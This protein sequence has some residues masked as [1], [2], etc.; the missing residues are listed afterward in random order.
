M[1]SKGRA[2]ARWFEEVLH[3]TIG[4]QDVT[5]EKERNA[6]KIK[7]ERREKASSNSAAQVAELGENTALLLMF[8]AAMNEVTHLYSLSIQY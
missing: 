7:M 4:K 8:S 6:K 1:P 3:Y 2:V 5:L